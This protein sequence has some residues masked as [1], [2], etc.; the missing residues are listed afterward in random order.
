MN[1]FIIALKDIINFTKQRKLIFVILVTS[2]AISMYAFCFFTALNMHSVDLVNNYNG[3]TNRYL[4]SNNSFLIKRENI[5]KVLHWI[6]ENEPSTR[7]NLYSN[8]S[9]QEDYEN[10]NKNTIQNYK[11]TTNN[12]GTTIKSGDLIYY[13]LLIGT[14]EIFSNRVDFI[15]NKLDKNDIKT[16]TRYIL[17]QPNDKFLKDNLFGLNKKYTVKGKEYIVKAIDFIDANMEEIVSIT[18]PNNYNVNYN[19]LNVATIPYTTFLEDNYEICGLEIFLSNNISDNK[20]DEFIKSLNE[21]LSE[22]NISKPIRSQ[23]TKLTDVSF[24]TIIYAI[25]M[26]L[27]LVNIVALFKY[28]I[29]KNWRKYMIYRICGASSYKIY[30]ALV[31]EIS[32]ISLFATL[33]GSILYC[34]SIP[35][36]NIINIKYI[37]SVSE[38]LIIQILIVFLTFITTQ[39][40]I[41]K[42]SKTSPRYMERR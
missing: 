31:V 30:F 34:S 6:N 29:E 38:L 23:N 10:A 40:S 1:V 7:Y 22:Y 9:M 4:I 14:N 16:K 33:L 32:L 18:N 8:I 17:I 11:S 37:L 39:N 36:L 21:N 3:V 41:S 42:L 19:G 15:G 27:A 26:L 25:F 35:I 20:K 24:Y 5:N 12:S 28:W 2:I 13:N